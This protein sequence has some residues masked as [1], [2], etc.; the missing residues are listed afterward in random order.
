MWEREREREAA[1][2]ANLTGIESPIV[3]FV[4][5]PGTSRRDIGSTFPVS[6]YRDFW[7][8]FH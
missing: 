6:A 7:C 4:S 2:D 3:F 1:A 5:S 8:P